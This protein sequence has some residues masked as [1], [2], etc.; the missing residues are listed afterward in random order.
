VKPAHFDIPFLRE[1]LFPEKP[2]MQPYACNLAT[3]RVFG[4]RLR[5]QSLPL[6]ISALTEDGD[7]S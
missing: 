6:S 2:R 4:S 1:T 3:G 5:A 7:G